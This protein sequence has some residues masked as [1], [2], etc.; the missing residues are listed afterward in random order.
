MSRALTACAALLLSCAALASDRPPLEQCA[1][2]ELR[3]AGLFRVGTASLHLNDC[4]AAREQI[5]A[6]IP[7][8]FSLDLARSFSGD[9]LSNTARD[10]LSRNLNLASADELPAPLACLADAYVDAQAGDR[11]DVIYQPGERLSLYLNEQLLRSCEDTGSGEK[12]FMIWFGEQPFHRR[13]R[14][15]L[16]RRAA[17]SA[18]G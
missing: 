16:L 14:D 10:L 9:D 15:E 3:V 18:Q 11:Y 17:E 13:M 8:Q 12:Y 2:L 7:K 4:S 5:L 6:E 1:E